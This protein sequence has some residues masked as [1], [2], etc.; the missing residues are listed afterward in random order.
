MAKG[1]KVVPGFMKADN[2]IA[3]DAKTQKSKI[4]TKKPK[5]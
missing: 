5:K 1:K 2:S 4:P 3:K